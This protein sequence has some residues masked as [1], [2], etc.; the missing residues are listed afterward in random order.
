M[1]ISDKGS[2]E[3]IMTAAT[4]ALAFAAGHRTTDCLSVTRGDAVPVVHGIQEGY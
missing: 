3:S 1:K 4:I 2:G